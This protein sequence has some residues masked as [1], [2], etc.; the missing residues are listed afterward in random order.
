M[1]AQTR[2]RFILSSERVSGNEV[3]THINSKGKIPS[4]GGSEEG[5]TRIAASRV[6]ANPRHYRLSYS[7][8]QLSNQPPTATLLHAGQ[9]WTWS[10]VLHLL[11]LGRA[12]VLRGLRNFLNMDRSEHHSTDRLKERGVEERSGRHS[13]L[14]G[15][16]RPVFNQTNIGTVSRATLG[17][18]LRDGGWWGLWAFRSATMP[19]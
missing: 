14:H 5:G 8:P 15:R 12:E 1:C 16:K 9:R 17:R 4:T 18:L 6:T 7:G 10:P 19:S 13:T 11:Q 3:R 2:P